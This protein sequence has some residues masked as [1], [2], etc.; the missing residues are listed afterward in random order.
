MVAPNGVIRLSHWRTYNVHHSLVQAKNS[1]LYHMIRVYT[2]VHQATVR[3]DR[4]R[5]H[6]PW[7]HFLQQ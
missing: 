4:M 7:N 2:Y 5:Y 6:T 3:V 1:R